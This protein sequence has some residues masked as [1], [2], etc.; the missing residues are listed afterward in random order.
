MSRG[1]LIERSF[2]S[3][4]GVR[5]RAVKPDAAE[6]IRRVG[7]CVLK[8]HLLRSVFAAPCAFV[9]AVFG[10]ALLGGTLPT[11]IVAWREPDPEPLGS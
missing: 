2:P 5:L 7:S 1:V 11:A 4:D 6:V 10:I 8:N 9:C 3:G